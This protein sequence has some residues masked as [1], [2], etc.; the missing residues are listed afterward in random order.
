[1]YYKYEMFM[2]KLFLFLCFMFLPFAANADEITENIDGIWYRIDIESLEA[3][4]YHS[5]DGEPYKGEIVIPETIE[6]KGATFRVTKIG[7]Q[8]FSQC[9]KL[10]AVTIPNNVTTIEESAFTGCLKLASINLGEGLTSIGR[11]AFRYCKGLVSISLPASVTTIGDEAFYLSGLESLTIP[12][13]V[14]VIGNHVFHDCTSLKSV[15]IGDGLT[16]IGNWAFQGCTSLNSLTFGTGLKTIGESAFQNCSSLTTLSI[17]SN[18]STI[19]PAAFFGCESLM[20]VNIGDGV[21]EI[22]GSAF[23]NCNTLQ[24]IVLGSKLTNIETLAFYHCTKLTDVYCYAETVPS[25]MSDTFLSAWI[26]YA[27]LHVQA[28]MIEL[29]MATDTWNL[30]KEIVPLTESDPTPTAINAVKNE[31]AD[32]NTT[33]DLTGRRHTQPGKGIIIRNGKKVVV[34]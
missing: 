34:K 22:G 21:T 31:P 4:V 32:N 20:S 1:M 17:P 12:D 8:A 9:V 23:A 3:E 30:F 25:T 15:T 7:E 29:Y 2:K 14:T 13:G 6:Y 18:V 27:T 16:E 26:I 33:Y 28:S 24:S 19:G 10:T 5:L 11:W